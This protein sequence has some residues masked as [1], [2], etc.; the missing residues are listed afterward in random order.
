MPT[1]TMT[2]IYLVHQPIHQFQRLFYPTRCFVLFYLKKESGYYFGTHNHYKQIHMK[3][4]NRLISNNV[5]ALAC[6]LFILSQI[7]FVSTNLAAIPLTRD[8]Y[9]DTWSG[10]DELNRI[11]PDI[12]T[13][14][15]PKAN[16]TVG[17]FY[18]IW[19]DENV[20]FLHMDGTLHKNDIHDISKI[21][22]GQ[23]SWGELASFHHSAESLFG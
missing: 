20:N 3:T 21:K 18:F 23:Q 19:H 22:K 10:V 4:P 13:A 16:K 14:G 5:A 7:A 1:L 11:T 2:R 9:S 6:S 15:A 8:T 17:M 12:W